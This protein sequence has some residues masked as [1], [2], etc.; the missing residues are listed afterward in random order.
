M[1]WIKYK[2]IQSVG[3]D[4]EI[5]ATKKIGYNDKNIEIAK[6]EAYKGE[7][8]IVEDN[9][10]YETEPLAVEYGGTGARTAEEA[11]TNLGI[12]NI[13]SITRKTSSTC[14]AEISTNSEFSLTKGAVAIDVY[15]RM[16]QAEIIATITANGKFDTFK[17]V[18]FSFDKSKFERNTLSTS[19]SL[20][21]NCTIKLSNLREI[22]CNA[23]A[24]F[25][26][27]AQQLRFELLAEF[28]VYD[29]IGKENVY[30]ESMD[31]YFF[32]SYMIFKS[33]ID[34]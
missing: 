34:N 15:G 28:D 11:R 4:G 5:F 1:R 6:V 13:G 7:Y 10:E 20:I 27:N 33:S 12:D 24:V 8:E 17:K 2:I 26:S 25:Q 16:I 31:F 9:E 22:S 19:N 29:A 14:F 32:S 18:T 21:G 3:A 30:I 23:K